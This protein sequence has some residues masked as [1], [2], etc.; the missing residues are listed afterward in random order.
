VLC[1]GAQGLLLD[2]DHG[3]YPYVTSSSTTA[4]GAMTGLGFGPRCVSRV[5]GVAKAYTTRVGA[6]PFPTEL[7]DSIGER[8]RESGVEYGTTT[9]R[10]RRCGWL[11]VVILRYAARVNGLDEFAL[12]KL[13]VLSGIRRLKIAVAYERA[14]D[15]IECFPAESGI[16]ALAEW[17][18]VYVELPGW[19]ED[20]TEARRRDDLPPAAQDYIARIE[21][22]TGVPVTFVGVGPARDQAIV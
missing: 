18:P 22:L 13:D 8:I 16:G 1:E 15:R 19:E 6:G 17:Q 20:I 14:E 2:L 5:V 10:P 21:D 11:D 12:T 7:L 3:T 4:G 9:G